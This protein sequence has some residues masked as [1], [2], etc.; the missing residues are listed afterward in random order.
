[1]FLFFKGNFP[2]IPFCRNYVPAKTSF[3]FTP[4]A[5][6]RL[7]IPTFG[8]DFWDPHRKQ[9]SDSVFDSKDFG[10]IFFL[11]SNVWRVR[12]LEF[13]FQNLEFRYLIRKQIHIPP[14]KPRFTEENHCHT[15]RRENYFSRQTYIYSLLLENKPTSTPTHRKMSNKS[16]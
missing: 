11:N 15:R 2:G 8:S 7:W 12:K 5:K 1:M 16:E 10:R 13:R 14:Q 6:T 3:F 9:N 4:P